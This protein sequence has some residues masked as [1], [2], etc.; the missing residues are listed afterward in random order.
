MSV[1]FFVGGLVY[2]ESTRV[3]WEAWYIASILNYSCC[4]G[5]MVYWVAG[6]N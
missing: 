6:I 1:L 4:V 3:V 5:G 2:C